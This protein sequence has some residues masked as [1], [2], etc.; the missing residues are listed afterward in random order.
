MRTVNRH[1]LALLI[2]LSLLATLASAWVPAALDFPGAR[3]D[4]VA[5]SG[6]G[7]ESRHTDLFRTELFSTSIELDTSPPFP[8]DP[9]AWRR[10]L[11][12]EPMSM[13]LRRHVVYDDRA[14]FTYF[15]ADEWG[16]PVR[17]L[18]CW[19]AYQL[20]VDGKGRTVW[21]GGIRLSKFAG[22]EPSL[23]YFPILF[24]VIADPLFYFTA[25]VG[26][27]AARRRFLAIRRRRRNLCPKC[28]Y[29]LRATPPGSPCPECGQPSVQS[30]TS[31][32]ASAAGH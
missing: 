11:H 32:R 21:G 10:E 6:S 8:D 14:A 30:V 13:R 22:H 4:A 29:D 15:W 27:D 24:G 25:F 12:R 9:S 5:S 7:R 31:S 17:C 2:A 16:W 19:Q 28:A 1:R 3:L 23:P 26:L 20:P 18:W